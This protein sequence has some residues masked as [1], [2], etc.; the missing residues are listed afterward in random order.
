MCHITEQHADSLGSTCAGKPGQDCS[1]RFPDSVGHTVSKDAVV[2]T[3]EKNA[4]SMALP[5]RCDGG[6][7]P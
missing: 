1:P 7:K 4:L 6:F 2:N 3:I 5:I